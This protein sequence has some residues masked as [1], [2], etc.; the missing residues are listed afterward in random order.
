[1]NAGDNGGYWEWREGSAERAE[2]TASLQ[3]MPPRESGVSGRCPI[4]AAVSKEPSP[5]SDPAPT[6]RPPWGPEPHTRVHVPQAW[7]ER[8]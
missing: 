3:E 2:D 8:P 5:R 6:S 4:P 1:M 7:L